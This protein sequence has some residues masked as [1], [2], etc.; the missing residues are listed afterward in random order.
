MSHKT[1]QEIVFN[2]IYEKI[3][4][5]DIIG[6]Y[7]SK[8]SKLLVKCKE[9]GFEW[10]SNANRL[11][12]GHGCRKCAGKMRRGA[13]GYYKKSCE[14]F[15]RELAAIQPTIQLLSL[16]ESAR[17]KV[18]C[19][20]TVCGNQWMAK[21]SNLLT[22]CGCPKCAVDSAKYKQTKTQS[23]FLTEMSEKHPDIL[24]VGD[25]ENTS[26]KI[27]LHC[28]SCGYDWFATPR[29][30]LRNDGRTTGCPHCSTSHGETTIRKWLDDH[31][32]DYCE[33]HKYADLVGIGGRRLSYDFY[34]PKYRVLIEY[35]GEFHDHTARIQSDE[36][37]TI[38]VEHDR[39]KKEFAEKNMLHLVEV[40][41]YENLEEKLQ[42][43]FDNISD[44]VTTTAS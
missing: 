32:I 7:E 2:Q 9:C 35:Q 42:S 26:S 25:Y 37:Y 27:E 11:I 30:L 4:G 22:G 3:P 14:Q 10:Y 29:N 19:C 36:D 6:E 12:N 8:S 39:R 44:P 21:A 5:I 38:Q 20:C 24:V 28:L 23:Q 43:T 15:E 18:M 41:Y 40:W 34:I 1:P 31:H 16:Y 13:R 17:E 33:Q